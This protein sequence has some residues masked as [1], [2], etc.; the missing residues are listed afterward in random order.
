LQQAA[1]L[2]MYYKPRNQTNLGE[3]IV[4]AIAMIFLLLALIGVAVFYGLI[5]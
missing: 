4:V 2:D 5:P 3:K 1:D